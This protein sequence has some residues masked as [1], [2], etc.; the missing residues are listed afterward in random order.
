[1]VL[2][3]CADINEYYFNITEGCVMGK[4]PVMALIAVCG[5][6][7]V[8]AWFWYAADLSAMRRSKLIGDTILA[9]MFA[10]AGLYVF[11]AWRRKESSVTAVDGVPVGLTF[12]P[13]SIDGP[14][15]INFNNK[16]TRSVK[17]T[18]DPMSINDPMSPNFNNQ[19]IQPVKLTSDPD[20]NIAK[21]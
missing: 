16:P 21:F 2:L 17:L 15:G 9:L 14:M 7:A 5:A 10:G 3:V 1:V 6:L 18:F 20:F 8:G 19:F 13:M 4:K 12:D 11:K